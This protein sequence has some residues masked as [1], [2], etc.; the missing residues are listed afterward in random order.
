[1][2]KSALL[3][4]TYTY[5][6]QRFLPIIGFQ[7]YLEKPIIFVFTIFCEAYFFQFLIKTEE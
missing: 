6:N 3:Y 4:I 1:M 7:N 5:K 2:R